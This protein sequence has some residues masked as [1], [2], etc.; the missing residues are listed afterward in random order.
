MKEFKTKLSDLINSRGLSPEKLSKEMEEKELYLHPNTIRGYLNGTK[1]KDIEKYNM[2]AKFFDV[3]PKFLYDD[4][5]EYNTTNDSIDIG[6]ELKLSDLAINNI[7]AI[8]EKEELYSFFNTFIEKL[9]VEHFSQ[10]LYRLDYYTKLFYSLDEL[11]NIVKLESTIYMLLNDKKYLEVKKI[12]LEFNK[13]ID[14]I[15]YCVLPDKFKKEPVIYE[16]NDLFKDTIIKYIEESYNKL[17]EYI[18]M[19]NY[20]SFRNHYHILTKAINDY[21][22]ELIDRTNS[23]RFSIQQNLLDIIS[24]IIP[25]IS[26]KKLLNIKFIEKLNKYYDMGGNNVSSR[27]RKK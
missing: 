23:I 15:D 13:I 22:T 2:L 19:N 6:E 10:K 27:N 17:N 25:S 3:A 11:N 24:D 5:I 4:N 21:R 8:R 14:N 16:D 7:K 9:D 20:Q 1:P 12:M 18:K 26:E